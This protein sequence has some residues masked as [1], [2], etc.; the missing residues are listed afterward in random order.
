MKSHFQKLNVNETDIM[1]ISA[2]PN[3]MPKVFDH[4]S[5]SLDE[6]TTLEFDTVT[7]AKNLGFIFDDNLCIESQINHV[8]ATCY[9]KLSNLYRIADILSK[10]RKLLFVTA[11]IFSCLDYCNMLHYGISSKLLSRLQI[12]LSD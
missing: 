6:N 11:Y 2:Y 12:V 9:Y 3:L 10:K 7:K 8:V 1:K 5:I 4:L